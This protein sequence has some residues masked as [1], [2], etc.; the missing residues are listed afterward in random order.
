M[1]RQQLEHAVRD[2]PRLGILVQQFYR[3][4]EQRDWRDSAMLA[5]LVR[6]LSNPRGVGR[7]DAERFTEFVRAIVKEEFAKEFRC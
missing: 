1:V 4:V 7:T 5:G 6:A 2:N 3:V